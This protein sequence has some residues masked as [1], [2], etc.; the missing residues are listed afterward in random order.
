MDMCLRGE[1]DGVDA[2]LAI[3]ALVGSKIIF[4]SGS[5]DAKTMAR[6]QLADPKAVLFKPV[7]D[8][9]LMNALETAARY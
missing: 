1:R 5:S 7:S 2:A 6:I 3:R 9:E 8:R 4:L